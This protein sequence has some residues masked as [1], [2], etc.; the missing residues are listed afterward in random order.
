MAGHRHFHMERIRAPTSMRIWVALRSLALGLI[1]GQLV[2]S[3]N[4]SNVAGMKRVRE[5]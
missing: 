5:A 4:C 3:K 1:F 2:D